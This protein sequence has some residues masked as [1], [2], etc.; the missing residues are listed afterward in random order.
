MTPDDPDDARF[1]RLRQTQSIDARDNGE[2]LSFRALEFLARLPNAI[3]LSKR[4]YRCR[5]GID[6][7]AANGVNAKPR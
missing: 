7:V 2:L 3:R 4:Y 5:C 6:D 1:L